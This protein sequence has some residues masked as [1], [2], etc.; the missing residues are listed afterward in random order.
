M[1]TGRVWKGSTIRVESAMF[2]DGQE[3]AATVHTV[4]RKLNSQRVYDGLVGKSGSNWVVRK[5]QFG[6]LVFGQ[7]KREGGVD[8]LT[9][10]D[11]TGRDAAG[12]KLQMPFGLGEVR[13]VLH[14]TIEKCKYEDV[15]GR[16]FRFVEDRRLSERTMKGEA[17]SQQA[18]WL[19]QN[20]VQSSS[21][22]L[23]SRCRSTNSSTNY[24]SANRRSR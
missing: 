18:V 5:F 20:A 17:I 9:I 24:D 10:L 14:R 23:Q 19:F 22:V 4:L 12:T 16:K 3:V 7:Y 15:N 1:T 8:I 21:N 6:P 13:I 11:E 2:V